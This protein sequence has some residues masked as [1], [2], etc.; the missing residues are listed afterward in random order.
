[1]PYKDRDVRLEYSQERHA[2]NREQDKARCREYNSEN[3]EKLLASFREYHAAN[4]DSIN[5]K[6]RLKRALEKSK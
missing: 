2:A 5:A 6:K 4:R 1:M 3:R